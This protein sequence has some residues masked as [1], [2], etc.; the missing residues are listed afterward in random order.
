M[1]WQNI[2]FKSKRQSILEGD[3]IAHITVV[4]CSCF[5]PREVRVLYLVDFSTHMLEIRQSMTYDLHSLNFQTPTLTSP[6]HFLKFLFKVGIGFVLK[7]TLHTWPRT[8]DHCTPSTLIGGKGIANP[9]SL[10]NTLE[11]PKEYVNGFKMECKVYTNS[12]MAS[13]G[14]CFMVT[15]IIYKNHLLEVR[16]Q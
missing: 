6:N 3:L 15:W 13:N 5:L 7:A 8:H 16:L 4:I 14:P 9:S 2:I 11:G 1:I 10:H 12:Y